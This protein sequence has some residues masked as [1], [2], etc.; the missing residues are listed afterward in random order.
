MFAKLSVRDNL[1]AAAQEFK[2]SM[3][4]RLFAPPDAG[5]GERADEMVELFRLTEVADLPAGS[6][7]YG[8]QKLV[9]IAMAFMPSPRLVLLD[10]PCAGV[11]VD[12]SS[13]TLGF[14]DVSPK[15]RVTRPDCAS[16]PTATGR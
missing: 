8:Q 11:D 14:S 15:F 6:L 4:S 10:E 2:G 3:A 7:S 1:I 5:L 13:F 12:L 9:D 16:A